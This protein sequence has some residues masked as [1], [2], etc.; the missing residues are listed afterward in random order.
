MME[1]V[2]FQMFMSLNKE[3]G[4]LK[5]CA[6]LNVNKKEVFL[7]PETVIQLPCSTGRYLSLGARIR[8][9]NLWMTFIL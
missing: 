7:L 1:K 6:G 3:G 8:M 5:C 2:K 4:N 9:S